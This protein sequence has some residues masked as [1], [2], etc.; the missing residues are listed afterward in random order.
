MPNIKR[1]I[2]YARQAPGVFV[3]PMAQQSAL[4]AAVRVISLHGVRKALKAHYGLVELKLVGRDGAGLGNILFVARAEGKS[5]DSYVCYV[6][7][8]SALCHTLLLLE[9]DVSQFLE[10]TW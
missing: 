9:L 5:I 1:S 2:E 6:A 10:L 7:N 3:K 4:A 8:L